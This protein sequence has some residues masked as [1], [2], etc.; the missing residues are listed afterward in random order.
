[1]RLPARCATAALGLLLSACIE[2]NQGETREGNRCI[3]AC[4]SNRDCLSDWHCEDG[5][6]RP[7][8]TAVG[9]SSSSLGSGS[10]T[11]S[12]HSDGSASGAA[13]SAA[14]TSASMGGG[15]SALASSARASSS[16][17]GL[18]S[19]GP[20]P[21]PQCVDSQGAI[22]VGAT[23]SDGA[24]CTAPDACD[25]LGQ[26]RGDARACPALHPVCSE[27]RGQC[28]CTVAATCNGGTCSNHRCVAIPRS[29]AVA[30]GG[31]DAFEDAL[32]TVDVNG[33]RSTVADAGDTLGFRFRG[34]A[35]PRGARIRSARV[36]INVA[37]TLF[38]NPEERWAFQRAA[39][40]AAF[41]EVTG[42]LSART[43]TAASADWTTNDVGAGAQQGP[44]LAAS[45]Q[46][47]VDLGG[48]A[49]GNDAVVIARRITT[50]DTFEVD[51]FEMG[52]I[53]AAVLDVTYDQP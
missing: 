8:T 1:M 36:T 53:N 25:E 12:S 5:R 23:C 29:V 34:V 39:A 37:S 4:N 44:E 30:G 43:L 22:Q 35:V 11:T 47:V 31:D 52:S 38:D 51:M 16:H 7:G 32:G 18:S 17:P 15:S 46:E 48:W 24:F 14:P 28:E 9:G 33:M 50:P 45:L 13:S 27:A 21:D 10:T 20:A 6:C 42:N 49:S 2:C 41:Q 40:P 26:C 19:S 3:R